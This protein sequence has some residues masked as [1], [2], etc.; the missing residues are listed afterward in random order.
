MLDNNVIHNEIDY[1]SFNSILNI[2]PEVII[3][4]GG[5]ENGNELLLNKFYLNFES[6]L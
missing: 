3:F 1:L 6:N 5:D 2:I 4:I